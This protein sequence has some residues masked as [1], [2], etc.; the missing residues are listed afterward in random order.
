MQ[1]TT[2]QKKNNNKRNDN[3]MCNEKRIQQQLTINNDAMRCSR[4][5]ECEYLLM[6]FFSAKGHTHTQR[7]RERRGT[8]T[9]MSNNRRRR[10]R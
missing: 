10:V 9:L 6:F 3:F 2:K 1:S 7:E 5:Y 8:D 4:V